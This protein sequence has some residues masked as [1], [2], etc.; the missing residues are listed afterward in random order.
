MMKNMTQH[1]QCLTTFP[2]NSLSEQQNTL[3]IKNKL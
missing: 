3:N 2:N 1:Q